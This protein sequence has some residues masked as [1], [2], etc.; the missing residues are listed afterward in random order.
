MVHANYPP[1]KVFCAHTSHWK[2]QMP[3]MKAGDKAPGFT[4]LDDTG[5]R[6]SFSDFKGKLVV[7]LFYSKDYIPRL[8][9]YASSFQDAL[10]RF[11]GLGAKALR[12]SPYSASKYQ[13]L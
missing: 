2:A 7:F 10:P 1:C 3:S 5:G 13:R 6:V 9:I 4:A 8:N 11:V 12:S